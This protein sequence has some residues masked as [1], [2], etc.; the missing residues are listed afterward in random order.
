M[1]LRLVLLAL[2]LICLSVSVHAA[3]GYALIVAGAPHDTQH[4]NWYWGATS[5]MYDVLVN[6]YHYTAANIYFYFCDTASGDARV[7]GVGAKANVQ[8]ALTTLAGKLRAN[9]TLFCYFVGHGTYTGGKSYFEFTDG[10]VADATIN[11]WRAGIASP[12]QTWCF[13]QCNSGHFAVALS[14]PGTVVLTSVRASETN[15]KS[16]AEP[17]RDALNLA[18]GSDANGDGKVSFAEAFNYARAQVISQYGTTPLAEHSQL[19]DTGDGQATENAAPSGAE[20][21][22]ALA[23]FLGATPAPWLQ[24]KVAQYSDGQQI[25]YPQALPSGPVILCSAQKAGA[26]LMACAVNNSPTGFRL[27]LKDHAGAAVLGA[28][29]QWLAVVPQPWFQSGV[30]RYPTNAQINF[31]RALPG[32]PLVLA[33]AQLNMTPMAAAATSV[34]GTGFTLKLLDQVGNPPA[35]PWVQWIAFSLPKAFRGG[36]I[37]SAGNQQVTWTPPLPVGNVILCGA[38]KGGIPLLAAAINNNPADFG[39]RLLD[40]N[41]VSQSGASATWLAFTP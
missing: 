14:S 34:S 25:T 20:G 38:Q 23:R 28:W 18:A 30:A 37:A 8:N 6:R 9:D 39:L 24:G 29:V 35:S 3:T 27:A 16:W 10:N 15:R 26:P 22:T 40:V 31:S 5:G 11:Q 19:E 41:G 13:S 36:I 32:T 2:L 21:H 7:D 17:I 12:I 33:N 4:R 1:L